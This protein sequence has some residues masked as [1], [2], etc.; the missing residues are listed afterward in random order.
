M[1]VQHQSHHLL[2]LLLCRLQKLPLL[3]PLLLRGLPGTG[4]G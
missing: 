1:Q 2:L 3:L 4:Y